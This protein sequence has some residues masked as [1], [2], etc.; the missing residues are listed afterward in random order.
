MP[1]RLEV[2]VV[3]AQRLSIPQHLQL[4]HQRTQARNYILRDPR[5]RHAHGDDRDDGD[6]MPARRGA[7]WDA[8]HA[9][10]QIL[11]DDTALLRTLQRT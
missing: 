6:E 1:P 4:R 10:G 7:S 5:N 11:H 3:A 2:E 8:D 9:H